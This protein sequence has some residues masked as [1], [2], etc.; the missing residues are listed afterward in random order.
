MTSTDAEEEGKERRFKE[1]E[2][3]VIDV[4]P[5]WWPKHLTY[6]ALVRALATR[7][8]EDVLLHDS[9]RKSFPECL[10]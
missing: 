10:L 5:G 4:V 3:E 7:G 1:E 6:R 2:K 8:D 9:E